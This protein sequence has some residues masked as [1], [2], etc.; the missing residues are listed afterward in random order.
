M[1]QKDKKYYIDPQG[2]FHKNIKPYFN[3]HCHFFDYS[4]FP[5][6]L[7]EHLI[8]GAI[9]KTIPEKV[10]RFLL[11]RFF[12]WGQ[13]SVFLNS[14][15]D[16]SFYQVIHNYVNY[17]LYV[18]NVDMPTHL[19]ME[20][21]KR[22]AAQRGIIDYEHID[23]YVPLM[24]DLIPAT[25]ENEEFDV[26]GVDPY[27]EQILKISNVTQKYPWKV[28]PFIMFDPRRNDCMYI[29]KMAIEELGFIGVKM[30]PGLGYYPDPNKYLSAPDAKT[31]EIGNRLNELYSYCDRN[32]VPI[33]THASPG[34]AYCVTMEKN[35]DHPYKYTE[36]DNWEWVLHT[37]KNLKV[38]FAHFGG[39]HIKSI[40]LEGNDILSYKWN[41]EII[42]L[43]KRFNTENPRVYTDIAFHDNAF[44]KIKGWNK[45]FVP[46]LVAGSFFLGI[47]LFF[48]T[49][50][51][52]LPDSYYYVTGILLAPGA[53]AIFILLLFLL[54][55]FIVWIFDSGVNYLHSELEN[56]P[57]K[58]SLPEKI[59][60]DLCNKIKEGENVKEIIQKINNKF[61]VTNVVGFLDKL[62][63]DCNREFKLN[64]E[65]FTDLENTINDY[66]EIKNYILFG[67]DTPMITGLY[68]EKFYVDM[69]L[70]GIRG[71]K[72]L[73]GDELIKDFFTHNPI[74]FL[75]KY[76]STTDR[77]YIPE[78]YV[79]FLFKTSEY[80]RRNPPKWVK[81]TD[82]IN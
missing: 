57:Y 66:P 37:Y 23:I 78:K 62:I 8:K 25:K 65:Y 24:M 17:G 1:T 21:A 14:F 61:S 52:N 72:N 60:Q 6:K 2:F 81:C 7:S 75:L 26:R 34:G 55:R 49:Y 43:M 64:P 35:D 56:T 27:F 63:V 51:F 19:W 45:T 80:A 79:E 10:I 77:Y 46:I 40:V 22:K 69:F 30:Y 33:T 16:K 41:E 12:L 9:K 76:D 70:K 44:L 15:E 38:N 11:L 47:V 74:R 39:S 5:D 20:K 28:F 73:S 67:T 31:K 54:K 71:L 18:N 82:L 50:K 3:C 48:I 13:G 58:T 59:F 4:F 32:Q 36:I 53:I 42:A 68:D 29:I